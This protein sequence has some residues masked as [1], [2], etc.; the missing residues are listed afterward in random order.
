[1]KKKAILFTGIVLTLALVTAGAVFASKPNKLLGSHKFWEGVIYSESDLSAKKEKQ[2]D[3]NFDGKHLKLKFTIVPTAKKNVVLPNYE[4]GYELVAIPNRDAY[5]LEYSGSLYELDAAGSKISKMLSDNTSGYDF[6]SL[7][8][9][10]IEDLSLI[11]GEK[12][13]VSPNGEFLVYHSNRDAVKNGSGNGQLWVKNLRTN[14]EQAVYNGGFEVVGWGQNNDVFLRDQDKL[15]RVN[16]ADNTTSI[17]KA[18]VSLETVVT[19]PFLV[20]PELGKISIT[21]INSNQTVSI[22]DGIGRTDLILPDTSSNRIAIKHYPDPNS[23]DNNIV[24]VTDPS[25]ASFKLVSPE[26]GYTIDTFSWVDADTLLVV[27]IKKGSIEQETYTVNI[28]QL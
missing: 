14:S 7:Q 20:L 12:A 13:S 24:V 27:A 28:N 4:E 11:W 19:Y 23:F 26:N 1:V 5:V 2:I 6:Q 8:A 15:A 3:F 10:R 18:N 17:V 22:T 16:L 25:K 21:D 9:K